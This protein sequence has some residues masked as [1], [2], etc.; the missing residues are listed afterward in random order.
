MDTSKATNKSD[1]IKTKIKERFG[2]INTD[3]S[4]A[5]RKPKSS[6]GI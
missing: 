6:K 1:E 4:N 2:K 5:V 3:K